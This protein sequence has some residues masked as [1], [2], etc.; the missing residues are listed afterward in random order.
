ML[1]RRQDSGLFFNKKTIIEGKKK[2][3]RYM[4]KNRKISED[5]NQ[6]IE[7]RIGEPIKSNGGR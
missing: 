4:S 6:K 5:G 7:Q 3:K 2:E 1:I